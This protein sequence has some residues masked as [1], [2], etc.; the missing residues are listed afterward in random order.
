MVFFRQLNVLEIYI[1]H[2][3]VQKVKSIYKLY[4]HSYFIN[5]VKRFFDCKRKQTNNKV[6]FLRGFVIFF[7][8]H[9]NLDWFLNKMV[10]KNTKRLAVIIDTVDVIINLQIANFLIGQFLKL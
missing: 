10:L 6:H 7:L 9:N 2:R 1:C 4:G 3:K 8:F 5:D